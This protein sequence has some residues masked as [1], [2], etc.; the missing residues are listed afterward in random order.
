MS[1]VELADIR[2][3]PPGRAA[4]EHPR[5]KVFSKDGRHLGSVTHSSLPVVARIGGH[6]GFRETVVDGQPAWR[7][8]EHPNRRKPKVGVI[9]VEDSLKA[10]KGSVGKAHKPETHARPRRG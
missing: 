7:E 6:T 9:S 8:T 4:K 2:N 5:I 10:A 3:F 1:K